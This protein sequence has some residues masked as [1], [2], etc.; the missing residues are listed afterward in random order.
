MLLTKKQAAEELAVS[1]RT[2]QRL[3]DDGKLTVVRVTDS[4]KGERIHP[5]D[6]KAYVQGKRQWQSESTRTAG[7]L[8]LQAGSITSELDKL[9]KPKR[10]PSKSRRKSGN[11]SN[12]R[13]PLRVVSNTP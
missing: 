9:L 8:T 5:D 13:P 7:K 3:I 1:P 2:V 4:K 12:D 11:S 6:L 10:K